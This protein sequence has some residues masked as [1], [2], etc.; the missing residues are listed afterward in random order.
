MVEGKTVNAVLDTGAEVSVIQSK[1]A[2]KLFQRHE[3]HPG[4]LR[5]IGNDKIPAKIF[6]GIEVDIGN[7]SY[8]ASMFSADIA[9]ELL[10]GLDFFSKFGVEIDFARAQVRIDNC[11]I[12]AKLVT[13]QKG[14]KI[15]VAR[16]S[17]VGRVKVPAHSSACAVGKLDVPMEECFAFE[18]CRESTGCLMPA[19]FQCGSNFAVIEFH[20]DTDSAI[21]V[22]PKTL[23]GTAMGADELSKTNEKQRSKKV[24]SVKKGGKSAKLPIYLVD[25]YERS[26]K[27]LT[28]SEAAELKDLMI[29]FAD[30]F[31]AHDMDLGCFTALKHKINLVPGAQPFR[32]KLRR[33]PLAMEE[34]EEKNLKAM[35]D[36]GVIQPSASPYA[37]ATVLV[38]KKDGSVRWCLDYRRLNAMTVKDSHS[39]PLISDCLDSLGG[40]QYL[41]SLDMASGYWQIEVDPDDRE[42]TAF[43]TRW[44][45]FEHVRMPFGLCNAPST[46]QRAMN[47]V[48]RGLS[49][50]TVLAFLD[51]ALVLGKDFKEHLANL[52]EVLQRFRD[53]NLKLKPRKC[54]LFQK[55]VKFLGRIVTG[56]SVSV[57]P[58]AQEAIEKWPVPKSTKD[59]ESFLG[60]VNYNREHIPHLADL[61]APLYGLTGK[62]KFSWLPEHQKAFESLKESLLS[63]EVLALPR[64]EGTFIL[65]TDASK[66]AIGGQ[67]SQIQDGVERPISFASVSLTP[68]QRRYCTTRQ[69]L[70]ALLTFVRQFRHY[71]YGRPFIVRTDHSSLTWLM[72]FK[73]PDGQLARWLEELQQYNMQV[74]YRRG[75][76]HSNADSLSRRSD[77]LPF[78]EEYKAGIDIKLLPCGGC[79]FCTRAHKKWHEFEEEVDDVGPLH[80]PSVRICH[81]NDSNWADCLNMEGRAEEQERDDNLK[82]IRTWLM[83]D[84]EPTR[85]ELMLSSPEVKI[86]WGLRSQLCLKDNVLMYL[87]QGEEDRDLYVVPKQ[88][89]D[90]ILRLGHDSSLS[91]HFGMKKTLE[92]LR[93]NFYWPRMSYSVERH[94]RGCFACNRSKHL[95]RKYRAPLQEFSAGAP[96]EKVHVDILGPLPVTPNGNRYILLIVDQFSKWIEGVALKDQTAESV[97]DAMVNQFFAR[98]GCPQELVSD[99]G[100]NF[101]SQVFT[102]LC[103]RLGISKKRT[104][105]FRPCA[106]GQV[107]RMNR[108]LLQ[109]IRCHLI[110]TFASQ[111]QWDERLQL[112]MGALR[113]TENRSTGF[114]PNM[115][116]LG[117]EVRQ[118]LELMTGVEFESESCHE[119]VRKTEERMREIHQLTRETLKEQQRRQKQD[120]EF[121][122]FEARYEVGDAVFLANSASK[123]GQSKKL[124]ALWNGPFIVTKVISPILYEI[125]SAKKSMVVHH[126]RMRKCQDTS[127]PIW[128][129]RRRNKLKTNGIE[130]SSG[131]DLFGMDSDFTLGPLIDEPI[132]CL[133]RKPYGN[134]FMI[135][136]DFC[137]EWY[138]GKC[139]RISE[140]KAKSI[141]LYRC[142]ECDKKG[143]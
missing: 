102:E 67:L 82:V 56:E 88:T 130:G 96:L 110:E 37:S 74:V 31:A 115:L 123:V 52:R 62:N 121:R 60:F 87:W 79:A 44:G 93:R 105:A 61:A 70:L 91:G 127:L 118:P 46:F 128:L 29:E 68:E 131:P 49:W 11:T 64:K 48:L 103:L 69:E 13:G 58:S 85:E 9:D 34:E 125:S 3:P 40:S 113:C 114:T 83:S 14:E 100:T 51:D 124:A 32:D 2:D 106:N 55:E 4:S 77:D 109:M 7:Q 36:A 84:G 63:A 8:L 135:Q 17:L 86:L 136:C 120:Y 111:N 101:T 116:M 28:P 122:V 119:F 76:D 18:P 33:A 1:L 30:V 75:R 117:R 45:L 19:T 142:P 65:D 22:E 104:T 5:G 39:L 27:E 99:Q 15:G 132:Y 141:G 66:V 54:H 126:D 21:F 73:R 97:A 112:H 80:L 38:R 42:K 108:N 59:V 94:V 107:E 81:T 133:C 10:L 140:K 98:F 72:G 35:L 90:L 24:R 57:D 23:L 92:R 53:Y 134:Q 47:L 138:H 50:N 26:A 143:K 41:S 129:N 20:N 25:L 6:H 89:R 16:V 78:C 137:H 12:P 71:L 95:R 139:V 43:I